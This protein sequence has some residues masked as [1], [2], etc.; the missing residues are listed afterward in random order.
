[1][2]VA[3]ICAHAQVTRPS[4]EAVTVKPS[5]SSD[6]GFTLR[7][8]PGGRVEGARITLQWLVTMAYHLQRHQVS[9]ALP[10]FSTDRYDIHAVAGHAVGDAEV[11]LMLQSLLEDQFHL[12]YHREAREMTV[13]LL[14]AG[15]NGIASAP[16][17]HQSPDG[18][19]GKMTTPDSVPAAPSGPDAP[20]TPCG[21]VSVNAGKITGHRTNMEEFAGSLAVMVER[22]VLNR[23]GLSGSYDLTLTWTPDQART[24]D[25]DG[26]SL[27]AALEEQL[28]LKLEAGKGPVELLIVDSAV[29]P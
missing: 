2:S 16:N 22:S 21:G 18:D 6:P 4:F 24:A 28:G 17:I 1:M 26:P 8:F 19:C 15:K 12:K 25:D 5:L 7:V 13:Y 3:V 23:T 14:V 9:S 27:F 10:G 20:K 29:K 11:E